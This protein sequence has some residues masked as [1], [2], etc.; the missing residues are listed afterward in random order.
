M[1]QENTSYKK[2]AKKRLLQA[3]RHQRLHFIHDVQK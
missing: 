3:T 2:N 1:K